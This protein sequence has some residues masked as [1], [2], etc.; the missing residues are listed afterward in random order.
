[1]AEAP[2]ARP[3]FSQAALL[4]AAHGSPGSAG[5]RTSTRRHAADLAAR[6]L[7]RSVSSGFLTEA[8]FMGDVLAGLDADEVYVVPNLAT[9]GYTAK[10]K[11]P[12][13]LKLTGPVTERL[14][15][16]RRQRI[17]LCHPV[18][19]HPLMSKILADRIGR[20]LEDLAFAP[21]DTC[22]LVVGHGSTKGRESFERT[23]QVAGELSQ[24]GLSAPHEIAFLD[25]PPFIGD[26]RDMTDAPNVLI[27]PFLISD[28][29]H[30]AMDIPRAV[31]MDPDA[32]AFQAVLADGGINRATLD[33]R[34]VAYLP[35]AGDAPEL[36][37]VILARARA[38]HELDGKR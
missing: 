10:E 13:A 1:M 28:G 5:G 30:A 35:A 27:A 19:T 6:G 38:A 17:H 12:E 34:H 23:R 32:A 31:G 15:K 8:P 14:R 4:I 11:L 22:V 3:D 20:A 37:D 2:H 18:G 26:W 7:F 25:E 16:G 33:G 29:F 24:Y 9:N 36:A 21:A